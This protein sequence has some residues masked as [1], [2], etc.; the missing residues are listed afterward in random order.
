MDCFMREAID[1]TPAWIAP[2]GVSEMKNV[3]FRAR[4]KVER[5]ALREGVLRIAAESFYA[6]YVNG[7]FVVNGPA[8]GT[9]T[10]NFLDTHDI[11]CFLHDGENHIAVEVFCNNYPTFISSPAEPALFVQ[12]GDI[13]TDESWQVQIAQDWRGDVPKYTLQ[14]GSMEW[15]DMGKEPLGWATF[16]DDSQWSDANVIS[17][18]RP[19]YS[20]RLYMRDVCDLRTSH[21]QPTAVPVVAETSPTL[22]C[23]PDDLAEFI[24]TEEFTPPSSGI[25]V[26]AIVTGRP[27]RIDPRE[28]D[29]G[30]AVILDFGQAIIGGLELNLEAPS[31]TI[32]DVCYEEFIENG[33]LIPSRFHYK[34]AD[35]YILRDGSQALNNVLHWRGGRYV[36]LIFRNF[37]SPIT[38][39]KICFADRRYPIDSPAEFQCSDDNF[40]RLW[41]KCLA[42]MSACATD[43]F[44]DCPWRE[45]A[46]WVND[47]LV[48]QEFWQ[49]LV[50]KTDLVK[51]SLSLALSQPVTDGLTPGVCPFDGNE[52]LVLFPT[53]LF[54]AIVLG[55]YNR[56]TGDGEF[57]DSVLC[58]VEKIFNISQ[59][60]SDDDLLLA[61][62]EKYWNFTDWS[63]WLCKDHALVEPGEHFTVDGK[64]ICIVN[65]F[66]C[67]AAKLLAE[68]YTSRDE[69]KAEEYSQLAKDI[70]SAIVE[71]FWDDE[72]DC[73]RELLDKSAPA[74]KVTHSLAILC[75]YLPANLIK[76]CTN[77]L[78]RDDCLTPE[79]Y[80]MH[81]VFKAL[82]HADDHQTI[83]ETIEKY[84]QPIV[85]SDCPTIWEANVH[86]HAKHAFW[87]AGSL[88][89]A[90]ALAPVSVFQQ[91]ILGIKSLENGF[92]TFSV[93]PSPCGL[94][95][96]KGKIPTPNGFIGIE[97]VKR[98]N[99][100]GVTLTV[101]AGTVAKCNGV[102][103]GEG[104]HKFEMCI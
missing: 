99:E 55:D 29:K 12:A 86:E 3:H 98:D 30:V 83:I 100:L 62:P 70:A 44:L 25:D 69:K 51:R 33:K 57:V 103:Y 77:A 64:K 5:E 2:T 48:Q 90:F 15:R 35:R 23:Q 74:S 26:Q 40:N 20:K 8:R 82:A 87:N 11:S 67:L 41:Q 96:A 61:P 31:G 92:K 10:C 45:M 50:G 104:L 37:T 89:H 78:Y 47:F 73:F 42:T 38:L 13:T 102:E 58:E 46:F 97:W 43:T 59:Q 88:C 81:F 91:E 93:N 7:Q 24:T 94:M 101:P 79:L 4:R 72:L 18:D 34:F 14:I 1:G 16:A 76:P 28:N 56:Y 95:F 32:L 68:L 17:A 60:Y 39:N 21:I 54:L 63:Y 80:M 71:K 75:D 36:Q 65:W 52:K 6:L 84:W 19:L 85:E 27:S 49:Q 66:N 22:Q 53:N 9:Y